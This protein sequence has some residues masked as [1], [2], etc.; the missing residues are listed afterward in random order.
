MSSL[1]N[2]EMCFQ[3]SVIIM[4]Y[5]FQKNVII[6]KYASQRNVILGK[7]FPWEL[8]PQYAPLGIPPST[9]SQG[10]LTICSPRG[11]CFEM[12]VNPFSPP[13]SQPTPIILGKTII[14]GI[15]WGNNMCHKLP[16]LVLLGS[17]PYLRN[18]HREVN[19]ELHLLDRVDFR[20]N[21]VNYASIW[22]PF[23]E[24]MLE[25]VLRHS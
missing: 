6:M 24:I 10:D 21:I 18:I 9:F 20:I 17:L 4:K 23:K 25:H 14:M 22:I 16:E 1:G 11:S 8:S 7:L 13:R 12:L 2:R 5:A 15:L 19:H 3:G